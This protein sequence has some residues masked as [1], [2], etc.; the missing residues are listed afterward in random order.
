MMKASNDGAAAGKIDGWHVDLAWER[1]E[2]A[3]LQCLRLSTYVMACDLHYANEANA[4]AWAMAV[5]AVPIA[6]AFGA[7]PTGWSVES[8]EAFPEQEAT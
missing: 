8:V 1:L 2:P 7:D 5:H 6:R 4:V 3:T